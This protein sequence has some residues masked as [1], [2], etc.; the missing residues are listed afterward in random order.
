MQYSHWNRTI[1]WS[2]NLLLYALLNMFYLRIQTGVW[3]QWKTPYS[4]N[5]LVDQ[6]TLSLNIFQF[7]LH[8]L[9]IA[10]LTA[11]LCIVPILISQLYNMLH[12]V[13]FV[14]A[15][16]FLG[17]NSILSLCL[18]VSCAIA[19]FEPLRFKSK[20]VA[21]IICLLPEMLYFGLFGGAYQET[22]TLRWAVLRAPWGL[23]LLF[24]I[25][26]IG[27]ILFIGH[28]LRYRPGVLMPIFGI[29]LAAIVTIFRTGIGMNERDFQ[30]MVYQY[31]PSQIPEFQNRTILPQIEEERALRKKKFPYLTDEAIMNQLRLEWK[32][33][34]NMIG[35]PVSLANRE[36]NS[37]Y[38]AKV[39]AIDHIDRFIEMHSDDNKVAEALYYKAL[40]IDLNVDLRTL[41]D[42]DMLEFYYDIPTEDSEVFW[43]ELLDKFGNAE[44]SIEARR[45]LALLW[46]CR[47]PKKLSDPF[48]FDKSIKL[49]TDAKDQC[50]KL[51]QRRQEN[52]V[53]SFWN[54]LLGPIFIPPEPALNQ[55]RLVD[56]QMRIHILLALLAEE[57]RAGPRRN[58]ERLADFVGLDPHKL[59]YE[60]K[61]KELMLNAPQPDP[62]QDNIELAQT[63]IQKDIHDRIARLTELTKQFPQR[64]GGLDAKLA[65]AQ[66]LLERR[67]GSEH[68]GERLEL[69]SQSRKLLREITAAQPN[70]FRALYAQ[71]LLE[72]NPV[73]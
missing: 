61:L 35:N 13:P 37:F 46:A 15:V 64:D 34:F 9:V 49:L 54:N 30:A 12:A 66:I 28:F 44:V 24:S 73:K 62:L 6:L 2:I 4:S 8:I 21:A 19:G 26:I 65:L 1:Y 25:T 52:I 22:D 5:A 18:F 17:H 20:F 42:K 50:K 70:A 69:L 53:S 60:S 48:N 7:P 45:R 33:A 58:S 47:R 11:L 59:N 43:Q 68:L 41:S 27:I 55:E 57:N 67:K 71:S 39:T 72:K 16:L 51:L 14:L 32:M 29:L 56:L 40:L 63:M 3:A 10:L 38:Q 23:A 36:V 31:S